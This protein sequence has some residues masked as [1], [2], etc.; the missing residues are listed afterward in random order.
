M[1]EQQKKAMNRGSL[2][3]L[4]EE[5]PAP[6]QLRSQPPAAT[7]QQLQPAPHC[8]P[9]SQASGPAGGQIPDG[10]QQTMWPPQQPA[11]RPA[12]HQAPPQPQYAGQRPM[13]RQ[14]PPQPAYAE[15]QIS[16]RQEQ[17]QNPEDLYPYYQRG[18]EVPT[19]RP[20]DY[21]EYPDFPQSMLEPNVSHYQSI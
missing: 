1:L 8:P 9:Q 12:P 15:Q 5:P 7:A 16:Y 6:Q 10:Q 21:E 20:E 17:E 13:S 4:M 19:Y 3:E 2:F 18:Q 14:L 11:Q